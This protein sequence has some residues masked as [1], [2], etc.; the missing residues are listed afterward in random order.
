MLRSCRNPLGQPIV[1]LAADNGAA[2]GFVAE[3]D[4]PDWENRD[5][6]QLEIELLF[7][8]AKVSEGMPPPARCDER[9]ALTWTVNHFSARGVG[10]RAGDLITTGVAATPVSL[11]TAS[12]VLA[13]FDGVGDIH[14]TIEG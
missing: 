11:G 5:L 6:K 8:G 4:I 14:V 7:D 1:Y 2:L 9:W 10:I 3:S 13:R 12:D